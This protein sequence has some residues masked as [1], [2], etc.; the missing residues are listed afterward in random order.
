MSDFVEFNE[1]A[2]YIAEHGWPNPVYFL[3]SAS[4]VGVLTAT[5]TLAGGVGE[6]SGTGY[7]RQSQPLPTVIGGVLAFATMYFTTGLAVDWPHDVVS[8]VAVTTLNNSGI[9]LCAWNLQ[10]NGTPRDMAAV[11]T[12]EQVTPTY[13]F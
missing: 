8:L 9:A 10:P 11:S 5:S 2:N 1:G 7:E 6:I 3:L 12:T 13:I 4:P